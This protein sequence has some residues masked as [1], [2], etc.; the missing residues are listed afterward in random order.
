MSKKVIVEE[1][2][3]QQPFPEY[4]GLDRGGM[5]ATGLDFLSVITDKIAPIYENLKL[6]FLYASENGAHDSYLKR[7]GGG[8]GLVY[9][10]ARIIEI[11]GIKRYLHGSGF[12]SVAMY[13]GFNEDADI[14]TIAEEIRAEL[15]GIKISD[16]EKTIP[17]FFGTPD[18]FKTETFHHDNGRVATIVKIPFLFGWNVILKPEFVT[19]DQTPTQEMIDRHEML[20]DLWDD[21]KYFS[22]RIFL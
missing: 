1:M 21:F 12:I 11:D 6:D 2:N 17:F 10:N 22:K 5:F 9:G 19:A 15:N 14:Y 20:W 3:P 8:G 4:S 18:K 13:S 16:T 7:V